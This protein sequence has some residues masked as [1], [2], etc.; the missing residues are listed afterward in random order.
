MI[1]TG[2]EQVTNAKFK[3]YLDGEFAFVLYKGE[4]SRYGIEEGAVLDK[5][6]VAKILEEVV[7]KRAKLR[8]LHLL[9][10]MDRSEA[11][12]REKLRHGMYPKEVI[13]RAIAY[14]KSFGYLDDE[15]YARHFVEGRKATKSRKEIYYLLSQKGIR[16]E[17]IEQVFECC[18]GEE[19]EEIEAIQKIIQKKRIDLDHASKEQIQKL[20]GYLSRKGFRYEDIR[21]V[22]QNR[23]ENA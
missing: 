7:L 20:C 9:E 8:A 15:R 3:I 11:G 18:Y 1:V 17:V 13:E 4:L 14:V 21:Q 16:T 2:L 19:N 12:L 23:D 10:G 5:D 22:I 6:V